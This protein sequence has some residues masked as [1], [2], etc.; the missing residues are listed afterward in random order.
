VS[1]EVSTAKAKRDF[2]FESQVPFERG[3][4][5]TYRWYRQKGWLR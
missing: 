1:W 4:K 5:E 2:G 3:A